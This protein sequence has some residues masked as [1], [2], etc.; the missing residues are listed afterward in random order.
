MVHLL[1]IVLQKYLDKLNI[2]Y[3]TCNNSVWSNFNK[4]ECNKLKK[5]GFY[6]LNQF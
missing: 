4:H 1:K 5:L 2:E 6:V 3:S